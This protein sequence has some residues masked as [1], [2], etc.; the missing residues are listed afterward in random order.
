MVIALALLAFAGI[1][2]D[3]QAVPAQHQSHAQSSELAAP[4]LPEPDV[5]VLVA[6]GNTSTTVQTYLV[7]ASQREPRPALSGIAVSAHLPVAPPRT[8]RPR[9]FP[10]LI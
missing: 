1:H 6:A 9:F 5:L 10:L 4:P 7:A 3:E 2:H 8:A